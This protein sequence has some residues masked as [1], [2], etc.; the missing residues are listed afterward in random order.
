[1]TEK[2]KLVGCYILSFVGDGLHGRECASS[3]KVTSQ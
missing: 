3:Q 1:M 2:N